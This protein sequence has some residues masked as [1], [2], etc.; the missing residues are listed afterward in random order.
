MFVKPAGS[1]TRFLH[2][3]G[4][5]DAFETELAKP[6]GGDVHDPSVRLRLV[7]LRSTHLP[8]PSLPESA[9]SPRQEDLLGVSAYSSLIGSDPSH[10]VQETRCG[11]D[12][13]QCC[14]P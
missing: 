3:I 14:C 8:S 5:A 9:W 7:T 2:H 13:S 11:N 1:N 4:N 6:L 12:K 10:V